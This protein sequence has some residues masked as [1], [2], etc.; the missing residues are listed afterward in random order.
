MNSEWPTILGAFIGGGGITAILNVITSRRVKR[1]EA[2]KIEVSGELQ[3]VDAA[4]G[5]VTL[6]RD[7]ITKLSS[8]VNDLESDK[9]ELRKEIAELHRDNESL[10]EEM[11][12]LRTENTLLKLELDS[13]A[14]KEG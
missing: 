14:T 9:K 4:T 5:L 7:E 1:A 8:R 11:Q 3:I 6:L 12:L 2:R 13:K 10:R